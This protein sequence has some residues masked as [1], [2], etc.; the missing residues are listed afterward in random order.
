M[1]P[2]ILAILIVLNKPPIRIATP[3]DLNHPKN[4]KLKLNDP[5]KS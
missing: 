1:T 3:S 4:P 5:P 2:Q